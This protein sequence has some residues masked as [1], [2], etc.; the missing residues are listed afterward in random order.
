MVSKACGS[1]LKSIFWQELDINKQVAK[2]FMLDGD[3]AVMK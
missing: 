2:T 3:R 1:N